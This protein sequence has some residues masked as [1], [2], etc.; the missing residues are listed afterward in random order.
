MIVLTGHKEIS[1]AINEIVAAVAAAF[2]TRVDVGQFDGESLAGELDR[3]GRITDADRLNGMPASEEHDVAGDRQAIWSPAIIDSERQV[4]DLLE[5]NRIGEV[6]YDEP[7]AASAC[8]CAD[9][10]VSS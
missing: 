9:E 3:F 1:V 7:P 4:C 10:C 5:R 6:D 8:A 2:V